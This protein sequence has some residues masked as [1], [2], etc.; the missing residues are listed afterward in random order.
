MIDY[1][2]MFCE[3]KIDQICQNEKCSLSVAHRKFIN[4]K[5]NHYSDYN[6]QLNDFFDQVHP[7]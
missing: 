2:Q 7:Y 3:M 4:W 5:K 1:E 6:N